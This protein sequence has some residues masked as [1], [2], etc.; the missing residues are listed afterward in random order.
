MMIL[1]NKL[2]YKYISISSK[3]SQALQ[4]RVYIDSYLYWQKKL[5]QDR[6]ERSVIECV[7]WE[8]LFHVSWVL[9]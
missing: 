6:K 4:V 1:N 8:V 5:L 3:I 2:I 9:F 7:M